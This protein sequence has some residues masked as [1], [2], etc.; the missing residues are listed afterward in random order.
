MLCF[1]LYYF[2]RDATHNKILQI[3]GNPSP[4]AEDASTL[5]KLSIA[6]TSDDIV[7]FSS[8]IMP[9]SD[10]ERASASFMSEVVKC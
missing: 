3:D 2:R 1:A 10:L 9:R 8:F 7:V 5:L 4:G 6:V